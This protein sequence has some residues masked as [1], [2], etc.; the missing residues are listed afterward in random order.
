[1][2]GQQSG[3]DPNRILGLDKS[4]SD[5]DVKKRYH[6]LHRKLHP[7]TSRTPGTSFLFQMV[8]VAFET[9]KRERRWQ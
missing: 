8:M 7:N 1:M 3:L 4:A 6:A 5:D 2:V 9:V